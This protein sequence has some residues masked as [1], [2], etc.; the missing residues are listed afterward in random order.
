VP[1][2]AIKTFVDPSVKF[3][4]QFETIAEAQDLDPAGSETAPEKSV[5]PAREQAKG[6]SRIGRHEPPHASVP[7]TPAKG[8]EPAG[9]PGDGSSAEIVS[10]D[11][12]R[13]K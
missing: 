7:S 3:A 8:G 11:R 5:D 1:F 4:L 9:E 10:L 12:F 2:A 13:K 6:G